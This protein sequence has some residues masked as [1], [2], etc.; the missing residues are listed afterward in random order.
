MRLKFSN[1][2]RHFI[3]VVQ[4]KNKVLAHCAK[5]GILWRGIVHD[6]SKFTPVE[7]FESARYY[8]GNRSPIIACRREVGMSRAWLHHKGVNKHHIEYWLD[9]DC[10]VHPMMPYKYAVECVCDKLA[11]T[12]T[13]NKEGYTP[14]KAME[15]W[16][17]YGQKANG[18]PRT[19]EFISTVFRD[20]AE[21]GEAYILNKRYM[22][23]TYARVC[24]SG[25]KKKE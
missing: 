17:R 10:D 24:L 22:R 2:L 14:S 6:L 23:E 18:N 1:A 3:L 4:H 16:V 8:Q 5:C 9:G 20:L 12:K 7:F 21:H 15:H 11:A 19:M 25:E 13:Y